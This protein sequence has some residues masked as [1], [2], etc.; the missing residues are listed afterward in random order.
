M[1]ET[2]LNTTRSYQEMVTLEVRI[3]DSAQKKAVVAAII[4]IQGT[5]IGTITNNNGDFSIKI[6]WS[7]EKVELTINHASYQLNNYQIVP[8]QS[9]TGLLIEIKNAAQAAET[10][11]T[12]KEAAQKEKRHKKRRSSSKTVLMGCPIF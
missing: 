1:I 6:P 9:R 3:W 2:T 12:P 4:V 5:D 8:N 10:I 7:Q 11:P